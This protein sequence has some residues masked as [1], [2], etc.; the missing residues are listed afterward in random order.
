MT[1]MGGSLEVWAGIECTVNRTSHGYADQSELSGHNARALNDLDSFAGLGIRRIRYPVL[2]ETVAPHEREGLRFERS[3]ECLGRIRELQVEPIVGLLHHGSGPAYTSLVDPRFPA[4]L[5]D[6][7]ARVA[8]RYPW[9]GAYTPVNEPLTT[10]RFSALYG[11]WYPHGRDERMFGRA[12]YNEIVGTA[13]AMRAIRRV[14]PA[15]VLVQTDDIGR[16]GG[17][18]PLQYQVE[19]EN[20]R[21][22]LSIDLLLG[23]VAPGHPLYRYLIDRCGLGADELDWLVQNPCPPDVVGVNHYPLSN[24]FLDHRVELYPDQVRGGNGVHEYADVGTVDTGQAES[25]PPEAVLREVWH[26]YQRPFAVTEAH[27]AGGREMQLRWLHEIWTTASRL[28]REGAPLV[29]VT[30]WSLLGAYDWNTLCTTAHGAKRYEPGVFD[31]RWSPPRP[32]V[33]ADMIRSV[34]ADGAFEHPLLARPGYWHDRGRAIFAPSALPSRPAFRPVSRPLVVIGVGGGNLGRAF[35][36]SCDA[37]GVD[38]VYLSREDVVLTS[39]EGCA[40]LLSELSPWAVIDAT[41]R[42]GAGVTNPDDRWF[43][44]ARGTCGL[45]EACA[46]LGIP[47]ATFSTESVFDG[48]ANTPYRESDPVSPATAYGFAAAD[49]ERRVAEVNADALV[50]RPGSLFSAWGSDDFMDVTAAALASGHSVR[51]PDN[52]T[53]SPTYVPDLVDA[54]LDLVADRVAGLLHVANRGAVSWAEWARSVAELVGA[55]SAR[56]VV[57]Q[58]VVQPGGPALPE[59]APSVY[60]PRYRVLESERV[61]LLA[62]FE[63]AFERYRKDFGS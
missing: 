23:R 53:V 48:A 46:R 61:D 47:F 38:H 36:H 24:R 56:V 18:Q 19:F 6:Y 34:A 22:W 13:L 42:S 55:D 28:R 4:L 31:V 63:D 12:L 39:V 1:M 20:E 17:T 16:V 30:A 49:S 8:E 33:L 15:A 54:C 57:E 62:S 14:N 59:L 27:I 26:R 43:D 25:P 7:A 60:R 45:A 5:G 3:D 50:I 32:T 21:R 9:V 37:R 29:A 2:W 58:G 10:A 51:A 35:S 41:R 11:F 44:N 52:V 40:E